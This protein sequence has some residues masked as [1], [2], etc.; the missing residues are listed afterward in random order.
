MSFRSIL[1]QTAIFCTITL[2]LISSVS[3]V[4]PCVVTDFGEKTSTTDVFTG[5]KINHKQTKKKKTN[6]KQQRR[7]YQTIQQKFKHKGTRKSQWRRIPKQ[8]SEST[9]KLT[10]QVSIFVLFSGIS[11]HS[12]GTVYYATATTIYQTDASN[13][14]LTFDV[15]TGF[16]DIRELAFDNSGKKLYFIEG[17]S[18]YVFHTG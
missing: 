2:C 10:S 5:N 12:N 18:V 17:T 13:F 9:E 15:A 11:V 8:L 1:S 7:L 3:A 6:R 14:T 16:T 4:S